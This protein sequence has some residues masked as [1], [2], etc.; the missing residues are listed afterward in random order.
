MTTKREIY[1]LGVC[2]SLFALVIGITF[3]FVA[4]VEN[5]GKMPVLMSGLKERIETDNHFY[6]SDKQVNYY[7]LT[8]ILDVGDYIISVGDVLIF[9][10]ILSS[11][12]FTFFY[13]H[14]VRKDRRK[15]K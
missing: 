5:E 15:K 1:L 13:T 9:A 6:H 11:G 2:L 10:S 3:N 12:I 4:V 14:N 8:D 7:Y